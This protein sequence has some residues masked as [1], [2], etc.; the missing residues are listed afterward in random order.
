LHAFAF[1][2]LMSA[3]PV[4]IDVAQGEYCNGQTNP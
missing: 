2:S 3:F 4:G 1:N